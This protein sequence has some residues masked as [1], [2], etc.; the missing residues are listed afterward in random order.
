MG[1]P[2]RPRPPGRQRSITD[3]FRDLSSITV[4]IIVG[5]VVVAVFVAVPRLF[6]EQDAPDLTDI[7]D[8]STATGT[9][10]PLSL[11]DVNFESG[12]VDI[13]A[14]NEGPDVTSYCNNRAAATGLLEWRGNRL[15]EAGGQRRVAQFVA[16]FESSVHAT[17]YL[18]ENSDIVDCDSWQTGSRG[19]EVIFTIVETT[20]DRIFG[21]ETK[22]F[23]LQ[24]SGDGPELFLQTLL[25]RSGQEVAQFTFVS[26]NRQDL[27]RLEDLTA[28][29]TVELGF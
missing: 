1:R 28:Q 21:D 20:P 19:N 5:I 9:S 8:G 4:A 14:D 16:Q 23:D 29:A 3:W 24:V 18:A 27:V 15:T 10:L 17:M 13:I 22:Q 6:G 2:S 11:D 7:G 12:T 26:V 25:V